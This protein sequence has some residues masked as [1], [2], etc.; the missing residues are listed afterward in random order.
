LDEVV[1]DKIFLAISDLYFNR[2]RGMQVDFSAAFHPFTVPDFDDVFPA[3]ASAAN[4]GVFGCGAWAGCHL[5][6]DMIKSRAQTWI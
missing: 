2:S 5:R 1:G 6:T 3:R 4:R